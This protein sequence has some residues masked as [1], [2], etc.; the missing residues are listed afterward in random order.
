VAVAGDGTGGFA[1]GGFAA[2]R[3][4]LVLGLLAGAKR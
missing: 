2:E 3:L 1:L 4:A